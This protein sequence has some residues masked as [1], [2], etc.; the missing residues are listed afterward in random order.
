MTNLIK[1]G[2]NDMISKNNW[3][4]IFRRLLC[5]KKE[6]V[7]GYSKYMK[8]GKQCEKYWKNNGINL[9]TEF[10]TYRYLCGSVRKWEILRYKN[11]KKIYTYKDWKDNIISELYLVR[12][13]KL[14]DEFMHYLKLRKRNCEA[15]I[16]VYSTHMVPLVV[17]IYVLYITNMVSDTDSMKNGMDRIIYLIISII[18]LLGMCMALGFVVV[19]KMNI[20]EMEKNFYEDYLEI[21]RMIEDENKCNLEYVEVDD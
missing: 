10:M 5:D 8:I 12:S 4:T 9:D 3:N 20:L 11:V 13:K 21:L 18:V 14:I 19:R 7:D 15:R 1:N 2:I 16:A 17:G 6:N